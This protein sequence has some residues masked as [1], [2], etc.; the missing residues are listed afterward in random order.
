MKPFTAAL[1]LAATCQLHAE[2]GKWVSLFNGKDLTGWTPKIRGCEA[3]DNHKDTYRV[4]DGVLKVD[5]SKY[6]KWDSRFGHLFHEKKLSHYRL[7]L[8][9]RFTGGQIKEGPGWALRNSGIMIHSESPKTMELEQDFPTSLEVQLLG[10]NGKDDRTTGNLCTPGTHVV[11]NDKL[12]TEHCIYSKS[13]TFH[14][15]QWVTIEIEVH[16]NGII[17]HL[18]NGEEVITYSQP[19]LGGDKHA[20]ALEK[21]AGDKML[22]EGFICLQSESHPV[23]F[24]KI[25]VMELPKP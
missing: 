9:Y 11:M 6:E 22:S 24:R 21:A 12:V 5:Y 23:E 1:L 13:K 15:D 3:G 4:E 25:E 14:G 19:Q 7:R 2:E 16:G 20:E 17:K 10:G 8:E 18:I